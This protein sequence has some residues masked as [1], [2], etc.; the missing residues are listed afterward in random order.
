M[1]DLS[2]PFNSLKCQVKA[3]GE[4]SDLVKILFICFLL[5]SLIS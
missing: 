2:S 1:Y 3:K 4:I 5:L